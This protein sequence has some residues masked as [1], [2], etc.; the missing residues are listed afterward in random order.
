M[1]NSR[2][3]HPIPSRSEIV[4]AMERAGRP[5]KMVSLAGELRLKGSRN[6]AALR[7]RLKAMVRDG[8]LI[9]NRAREYCLAHHLDLVIGRVRAHKDGYGF[10]TPD[11]GGEDVFLSS[12]EMGRLWDGDRVAARISATRRG[13]E[14]RVVEILKRAVSEVAGRLVSERGFD[15]VEVEGRERTRV[16]IPR[17]QGRGAGADDLVRVE[18]TAH[19][20]RRT[21][22]IGR[23]VRVLGRFEDPRAQTL[24]AILSHGIPHEFS[25]RVE[26]EAAE[27]PSGVTADARR[28]R[29]DLR[30]LPLVT[31]D[32]AD[33]KD[34]DDAVYCEPS[35]NGWRLIV[36]IADVG[37]YV[38][39]GTGLDEAARERGTSVYFPDR[40]VPMLPEALSN[41]LC[42]LQPDVE[43]LSLCC[44]MTVSE[45]G[46]VTRS[47]FCES[48]MR[49][50]R[51]FT[52]GEA[53]RLLSGK[54]V[55]SGKP[56]E[57]GSPGRTG[58]SGRFG[59][60]GRS[61]E[62]GGKDSSRANSATSRSLKALAGVYEAF[63]A[64]R[65]ERG[66]LEF[67][68]G[69]VVLELDD[70]GRI[71]SVAP[72]Q[73]LVTHRIIEEC[74]I[75]A[76]VE[77]A[78]WLRKARIPSV[79]RVHEGPGPER[80]DEL[81][82]VLRTLGIKSVTPGRLQPADMNRILQATESGPEAELVQ[83][84]LLRC[85]AR[86]EYRPKNSG[87]FGLAL[88]AYA[89]F[90]S[91]IRRYPDLLVHRAIKHLLHKGGVKGFSYDLAAMEHLGR[92]CS[93]A[94]QRAD[95]AVWD[96][97]ERLKSAWLKD[98]VGDCFTVS[99]AGIAPFGLFVRVPELGI[100]GL[101]HVSSLPRDYYHVDAGGSALTGENSGRSFRLADR[102]QVQLTSVS[103]R[104]RKI[105]F[106]PVERTRKAR[107]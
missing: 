59:E 77:A 85:M 37:H 78:K 19:P 69:E 60:S 50:A 27:M 64:R 32:G 67:D 62:P 56:R 11:I 88:P 40:V 91:P 97:E 46:E 102:L 86:A 98:R 58:E 18:I 79:Y 99:V 36:A 93:R 65:R 44:D 21:N 26:A 51:R 48:V 81:I 2:Y 13:S 55:R 80:V 3:R 7:R 39:A 30:K 83:T 49:S 63:L 4:T 71:A 14:G 9:R 57:S 31:I 1:K 61:G 5:L 95:E 75:A 6:E 23:V 35:G 104:E 94:E 33:A 34:F 82:L 24:S 68:L 66:G 105:D 8:Q 28:G 90:T 76:N 16:L 100:D 106:V 10:L 70:R 17:G 42:S 96:V 73:R 43:R 53:A 25:R 52:Y 47:R 12:R 29:K 15:W 103:V 38:R 84:M 89:H 74:M 107:H 20:T 72:R 87:H 41:G 92:H 101:V 22:A 54:S 45:Q